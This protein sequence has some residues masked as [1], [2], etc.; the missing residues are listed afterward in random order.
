MDFDRAVL[1][2]AISRIETLN[3]KRRAYLVKDVA[4][5]PGY[6]PSPNPHLTADTLLQTLKNLRTNDSLKLYYDV[7]LNQCLVLLVSFFGAAVRS[8]FE[9]LVVRS[10]EEE[11]NPALLKE[12]L[13][14]TVGQLADT[15]ERWTTVVAAALA[16]SKGVSFQDMKSIGRAFGDYCG[17]VP[18]KDRDVN[19]IILGQAARHAIVHQGAIVDNRMVRQL[20]GAAPR[21]VKPFVSVGEYLKFERDELAIIGASMETY[22]NT[23]IAQ[24]P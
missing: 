17:Y 6:T 10:L 1:N 5:T 12:E 8:L 14:L 13:V 21:A 22:L 16:E 3:D 23:V 9:S 4:A 20:E 7:M 15:G 18:N 19:N 2:I 11:R 24:A